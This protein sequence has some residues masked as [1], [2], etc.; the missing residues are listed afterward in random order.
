MIAQMETRTVV[1]GRRTANELNE[2][3]A[4]LYQFIPDH[5]EYV[6]H[7]D[8]LCPDTEDELFGLDAPVVQ[9][10]RWRPSESFE[11]GQEESDLLP[12]G[13]NLSRQDEALLFRRYNCARFHLAGLMERQTRRFSNS[14]LPEILL[15]YRRAQENRSALTQANLALVVAMVKRTRI[16]SVE[17]GE[18]V[19]E[20]NIALLRAMDK[21]DFSKGFKFSTYACCAILRAFSRLATKAGTY[22]QRFPATFEPGMERS[23]ELDRR[24]VD[25]S[26]L[27][28]ENL[29]R[30]LKLNRAGLTGV[31]Q[32]VLDARYA[33]DGQGRVQ[34][35]TEVSETVHLSRERIRQIQNG[36]LTKL[37]QAL[38]LTFSPAATLKGSMQ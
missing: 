13:P 10:S 23:D 14:R 16:V 5:V 37:R 33:V 20:G 2:T 18:L 24:H 3:D 4:R 27:A 1:T 22:H 12:A 15:W 32:T 28:L 21:F 7:P 8:Y 17:F 30:V 36:V 29:G 25:Q 6:P 26:E 38:E 9:V 31:E 35:L 34:T 19:S 11:D